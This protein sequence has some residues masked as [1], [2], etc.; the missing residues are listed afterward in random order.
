MSMPKQYNLYAVWIKDNKY[1]YEQGK[2][3]NIT[4]MMYYGDPRIS[5]ITKD[6]SSIEYDNFIG[7]LYSWRFVRLRD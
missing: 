4:I 7:F 6:D 1:G 2:A 3:Y 5:I